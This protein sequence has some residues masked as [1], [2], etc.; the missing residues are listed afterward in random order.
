MSTQRRFEDETEYWLQ[1]MFEAWD[2]VFQTGA[3]DNVE[4]LELVGTVDLLYEYN[5]HIAETWED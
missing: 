2:E 3:W 1:Q 5:H 4:A